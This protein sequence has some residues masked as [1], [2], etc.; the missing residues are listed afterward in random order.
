MGTKETAHVIEILNIVIDTLKY[1]L[2][3]KTVV[4]FLMLALA[5]SLSD[6]DGM[7]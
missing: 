3:Q 6:T 5:W 1:N 7:V 4:A 2:N